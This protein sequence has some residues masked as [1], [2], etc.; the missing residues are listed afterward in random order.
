MSEQESKTAPANPLEGCPEAL[1]PVLEGLGG[2]FADVEFDFYFFRGEATVTVPPD[3]VVGVLQ[4][5]KETKEHAFDY[6]I[7]VGGLHEPDKEHA[8]VV[9]YNLISLSTNRKLRVKTWAVGDAPT[10]PSVVSLWEAANW[11]EREAWDMYGIRF[12]GHP[13]HRRMFLPEHVDFHPLRKDYPLKGDN[14][15]PY[16]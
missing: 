5:V 15:K 16:Y 14:D 7:D 11:H 9:F 8:F 10:V 1:L 12:D 4:Y 2:A 6:L 3:K 13:D